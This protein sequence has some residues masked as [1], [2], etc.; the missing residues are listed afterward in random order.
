M[1]HRYHGGDVSSD[2]VC[3]I[4]PLHT[5]EVGGVITVNESELVLPG[6]GQLLGC[7]R[8]KLLFAI[9]VL[10]QVLRGPRVHRRL[11]EPTC[12]GRRSE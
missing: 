1:C 2:A 9:P 10:K 4:I 6:F 8:G 3:I 7:D 5:V 11:D 12:V